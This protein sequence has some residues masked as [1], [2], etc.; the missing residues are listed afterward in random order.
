MATGYN[1]TVRLKADIRRADKHMIDMWG[2][3]IEESG[4]S[5]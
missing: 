3:M 5:V 2:N 1:I 4:M